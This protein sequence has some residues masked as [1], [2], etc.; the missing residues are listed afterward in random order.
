MVLARELTLEE[1]AGIRAKI[2]QDLEIE[3]FVHGAMCM[4]F[5]GRCLLSSYLNGR[6]AN[7][8]RLLPALPLGISLVEKKRP[9]EYMDIHE[10]ANGT[11]ILNSRDMCMIE[12][13]PELIRAGISSLKIEGRAKSLIMWR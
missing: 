2:P 1:I 3:A 8:G 5:S 4:S 7:P 12:H 9:G 6:D 10:D 11:Y 13:I